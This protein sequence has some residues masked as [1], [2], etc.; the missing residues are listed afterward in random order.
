VIISFSVS[1][2]EEIVLK[3]ENNQKSLRK[4][5]KRIFKIIMSFIKVTQMI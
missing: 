2:R 4:L 1:K 5:G 3:V